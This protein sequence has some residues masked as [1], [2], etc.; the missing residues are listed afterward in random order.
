MGHKINK[1]ECEKQM[2]RKEEDRWRREDEVRLISIVYMYEIAE[3]TIEKEKKI[4][5]IFSEDV[6]CYSVFA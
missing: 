3:N 6:S 2:C 4:Q 5:H 1:H